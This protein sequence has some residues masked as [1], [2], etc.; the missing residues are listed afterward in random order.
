MITKDKG[1]PFCGSLDIE[2][3]GCEAPFYVGCNNCGAEG[4]IAGS[5]E[6]ALS[7]W[8]GRADKE[9]NSD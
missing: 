6:E 5:D 8:N 2:P 1:C 3:R 7:A 4:P 9:V